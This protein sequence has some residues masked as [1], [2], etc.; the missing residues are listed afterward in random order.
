M[1]RV[2]SGRTRQAIAVMLLA[3]SA[4][5][6]ASTTSPTT[7]TAPATTTETFSGTVTQLGSATQQFVVSAT[8]TVDI[9]LTSMA[10]LSTMAL[11]VGVQNS[12]GTTCSTTIT[13]NDNAR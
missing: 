9:M 7:T 8:G 4:G 12:D 3:A 2:I 5:C 10:P 13:Q 1:R 6:G 11:G